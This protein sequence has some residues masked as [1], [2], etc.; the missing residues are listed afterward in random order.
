MADEKRLVKNIFLI[1]APAGSGKTTWIKSM[2]YD[3]LTD[4]PKD[5]ILCITYTNRA[6]EEL[7]KDIDSPNIFIGTIHSYIHTLISP[8]FGSI[9]VIDLFWDVYGDQI[10]ERIENDPIVQTVSESN[11][12]YIDKYGA[13]NEEIV[14][15]NIT[16]LSWW[17]RT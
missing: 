15:C 14:R 8:F 9:Q 3:I 2:L 7:S 17:F 4:D 10:R 5:N 16:N 6:A 1:N 12:R 11:Q 13:L